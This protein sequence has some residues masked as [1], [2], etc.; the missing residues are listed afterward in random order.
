[1]SEPAVDVLVLD[2]DPAATALI[3]SIFGKTLKIES[4]K[5]AEEGGVFL[6]D[7]K[8]RVLVCADDLPDLPGLMYL[9][10]TQDRWPSMQRILMANDLDAGLLLHAMREVSIFHYLPKPLD[11]DATRHLIEHAL[12]Q[13][14]LLVNFSRTRQELDDAKARIDG[15]VTVPGRASKALADGAG[16]LF[17][18]IAFGLAL[19]IGVIFAAF[20][21]LYFL[22]T[23]LG[24]DIFPEIHLRDVM[25]GIRTAEEPPEYPVYGPGGE[26]VPPEDE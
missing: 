11:P 23:G 21:G 19:G 26:Y 4:R 8:V 10:Q 16:R 6:A 2:P 1:M 15:L 7:S 3:R 14:R 12:R 9:A 13:N 24:I 22:K 5:N 17:L 20:A 18:L 25:P